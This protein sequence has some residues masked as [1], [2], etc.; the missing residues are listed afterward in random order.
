MNSAY[1][2]QDVCSHLIGIHAI[3]ITQS[4]GVEQVETVQGTLMWKLSTTGSERTGEF[5]TK[6][7]KSDFS[8]TLT[9]IRR[10]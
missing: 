6:S 3:L 7:P 8:V 1:M 2:L 4:L 10:S 5:V 9:L